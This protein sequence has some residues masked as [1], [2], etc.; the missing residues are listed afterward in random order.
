MLISLLI[1][2][3]VHM[4][5]RNLVDDMPA[6]WF[7]LLAISTLK[8]VAA[9]QVTMLLPP[10]LNLARMASSLA[11]AFSYSNPGLNINQ[12]ISSLAAAF[13]YSNPINQS[14]S[15]LAA[16]FSHSNPGLNIN[17]SISSL[18]AAF[19]YSNPGLNINQSNQLSSK[20][21]TEFRII[22]MWIRVLPYLF[23]NGHLTKCYDVKPKYFDGHR[24]AA[25]HS[26]ATIHNRTSSFS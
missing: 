15:S 26:L 6:R 1:H 24:L 2:P 3:P 13:S 5:Y 23:A 9:R 7:W 21:V 19:S 11:A 18:A 4:N 14:I 12:S 17:Q 10:S 16:A 25:V 20:P 8:L 22:L